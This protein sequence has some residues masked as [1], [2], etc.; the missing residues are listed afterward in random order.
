MHALIVKFR[1][2]GYRRRHDVRLVGTWLYQKW[3]APRLKIV[4]P[5]QL[6]EYEGSFWGRPCIC[7]NGRSSA[8]NVRV[9][10]PSDSAP[11]TYDF[12]WSDLTGTLE[13][14]IPSKTKRYVDIFVVKSEKCIEFLAYHNEKPLTHADSTLTVFATADNAITVSRKALINEIFNKPWREFKSIGSNN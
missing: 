13:I 7:N 9:L 4:L 12:S 3:H 14:T 8:R 2:G 1:I 5:E 10:A 11:E 6:K